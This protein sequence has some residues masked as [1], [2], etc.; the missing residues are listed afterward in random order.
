[1]QFS[2]LYSYL[3]IDFVRLLSK[4]INQELKRTPSKYNPRGVKIF[5]HAI[6]KWKLLFI[7]V[8]LI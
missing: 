6:L 8:Y 2:E 1:M 5:D 3:L 7:I 4:I